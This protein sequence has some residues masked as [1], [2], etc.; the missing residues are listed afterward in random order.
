MGKTILLVFVGL[1][2]VVGWSR[3]SRIQD[4]VNEKL[5][6]WRS[7]ESVVVPAAD[8][9]FVRAPAVLDEHSALPLPADDLTLQKLIQWRDALNR[10]KPSDASDPGSM[11]SLDF[12]VRVD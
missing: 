1:V 2:G 12:A 5:S 4:V 10:T 8:E 6:E 9:S 7:G 3:R 11:D